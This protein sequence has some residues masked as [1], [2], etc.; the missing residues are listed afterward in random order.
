[1]KKLSVHLA[2]SVF[3]LSLSFMV[4]AN[5]ATYLANEGVMI[6]G[7]THK[8]LF[9]PFFHNSFGHYPLVPEDIR[10]KIFKGIAPYDQIDAIFISHAHEDHFSAADMH[11][12]L[13]THGKARLYAPSQAVTEL[14]SVVTDKSLL[15]RVTAVKLGYGDKPWQTSFGEVVVEAV[16]IPHA[17]G[18]GRRHIENIVFR[19][20][21]ADDI[22]VIHMG[23]ADPNDQYFSPYDSYWQQRV[24][25]VAFPPYWFFGH[26]SGRYILQKRINS[27]RA[28]GVHV[29]VKV[30]NGLA[31]SG[32]EFFSKPGESRVISDKKAPNVKKTDKNEQN[33]RG[34]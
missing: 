22:T 29:P 13:A 5:K 19:V 12:F 2:L 10:N 33:T 6:T 25:D 9:D 8:I 3:I 14:A 17:G 4:W 28:I 32:F 11:R 15:Q 1:M 7:S 16:R 26:Q 30:P 18:Q 27:K 34:L 21:L 23:D 20:S 31:Q 24:T